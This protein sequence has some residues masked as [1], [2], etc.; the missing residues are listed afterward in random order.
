MRGARAAGVLL[1]TGVAAAAVIPAASL[2]ASKPVRK[3]VKVGDDY[4]GPSKM[5]V[6][7]GKTVL[8]KW[9]AANGNTHDVKLKKHP[10]GVKS[11]HSAPATSGY[12]YKKTLKVKGTY[13]VIC[14]FHEGMTLT[15]TVK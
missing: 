12:T 15:I 9:L 2:G 8:W 11:F 1:A 5:T 14:T 10:K 13:K 7:K 4:F 6:S 3:T